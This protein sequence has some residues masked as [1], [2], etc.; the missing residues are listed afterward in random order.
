MSLWEYSLEKTFSGDKYY[1]VPRYPI[2]VARAFVAVCFE[3]PYDILGEAPPYQYWIEKALRDFEKRW[4]GFEEAIFLRV[5]H[6][7]KRADRLVAIFA[8]G[9]NPAMP[10]AT[11]LLL[12]FLSSPDLLE[13]CATACM[14]ALRRDERAFPTLEE[15]LL[16][17]ELEDDLGEYPTEANV[18][19]DS[20][21]CRI[22]N[23]LATWGP[24]SVVTI[25]KQSFLNLCKREEKYAG[26]V[27]DHSTQD[28]LCYA[29]GRRGALG[30]FHGID[31]PAQRRRL[32]LDYLALGYLQADE[33]FEDLSHEIRL[34]LSLQKET[35]R[36]LIEHFALSEEAA[37]E[38][39]K[40]FGQ[41]THERN[42]ATMYGLNEVE[43]AAKEG[44]E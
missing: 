42:C 16:H 27:Y 43:K 31:L 39:V 24:S 7:G 14:F 38:I 3:E 21:Q 8:I 30:A 6:E 36:V 15:D 40:S 29:L 12:P 41:D 23:L 10:Q 26:N 25:L 1:F 32:T 9:Y 28:A 2:H 19:Y 5:L 37:T 34:N 11:D 35:A 13:R 18:W 44:E 22:A 33:R 4:G 17:A 20:Y